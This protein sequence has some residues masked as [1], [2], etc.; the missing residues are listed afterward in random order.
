MSW[1]LPLLFC[2]HYDPF[3]APC[4]PCVRWLRG[5]ANSRLPYD[6]RWDCV[7]ALRDWFRRILRRNRS[8]NLNIISCEDPVLL[9]VLKGK[10]FI[11]SDV[12]PMLARLRAVRYSLDEDFPELDSPRS[13]TSKP[14]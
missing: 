6:E 3:H 9:E 7:L 2:G 13:A 5:F 8:H 11:L 10:K 14:L 1:P 12:D 4:L